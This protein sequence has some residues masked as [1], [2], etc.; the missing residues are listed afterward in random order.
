MKKTLLTTSVVATA[1]LFASSCSATAAEDTPETLSDWFQHSA[2]S[3][4]IA[5]DTENRSVDMGEA[6]E[7][8]LSATSA[9]APIEVLTWTTPFVQGDQSALDSPTATTGEWQA[10]LL[11]D[12]RIVGIVQA[13][14]DAESREV[15]PSG[16]GTDPDMA[17]A[18]LEIEPGAQ[19]VLDQP[20]YGIYQLLDGQV[21]ALNSTAAVEVPYSISLSEFQKIVAA[22]Y[23]TA[24]EESKPYEEAAVGGGGAVPADSSPV[25]VTS[26]IVLL[27][28]VG[29]VAAAWIAL[30]NRRKA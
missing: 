2:I 7:P 29:C 8:Y 15:H 9:S 13:T 25:M 20:S 22:R 30:R 3:F 6:S 12:K 16:Y 28:G 27:I 5:S 17:A 4:V 19:L 24:I 11:S 18:V 23:A 21:S 26:A 1:L 10:A 14:Y